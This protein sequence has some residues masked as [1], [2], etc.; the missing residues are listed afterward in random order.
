METLEIAQARSINVYE[1]I[2]ARS[3]EICDRRKLA[4][5]TADEFNREYP[6]F[7]PNHPLLSDFD[8]VIKNVEFLFLYD[9]I[10]RSTHGPRECY[11]LFKALTTKYDLEEDY[12]RLLCSRNDDEIHSIKNKWLDFA[13]HL[14]AFFLNMEDDEKLDYL[15]KKEDFVSYF[16][17]YSEIYSEAIVQLYYIGTL[18]ILYCERNGFRLL[19]DPN[20]LIRFINNNPKAKINPE[21]LLDDRFVKAIAHNV[22]PIEF[23][24]QLCAISQAG[25]IG[26][27]PFLEEHKK[28]CDHMISKIEDG[29]I[30]SLDESDI[31]NSEKSVH[32]MYK[33]YKKQILE[34]I[35]EKF[36]GKDIGKKT[37]LQELTKYVVMGLWMSRNFETDPH[38]LFIDIETLYEFAIAHDR[39]LKGFHFYEF[40]MNFEDADLETIL[41]FYEKTKD[42]PLKSILYDDW[43]QEKIQMIDEINSSLWS[44]S[45]L[46]PQTDENDGL[47]HYDITDL[48][49][50]ILVSNTCVNA[51]DRKKV[52]ELIAKVRNGKLGVIYMSLQDAEHQVVYRDEEPDGQTSI[53]FIFGPLDH[54]K[55]GIVNHEDAYSIGITEVAKNNLSIYKRRLYTVDELMNDTWR[56]NEISYMASPEPFMPIGLLA[57]ERI[58]AGER[59]VAEE[60][61]IPIYFRKDIINTV[62]SRSHLTQKLLEHRYRHMRQF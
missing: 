21:M 31:E 3:K 33:I 55:V 14:A 20:K 45:E 5:D 2:E 23:Y 27:Q 56:Y 62:S 44:L 17:R 47:T 53:K 34:K 12:N 11:T 29:I 35:R 13:A 15:F 28:F 26:V 41:E 25:A 36:K 38:N 30:P 18:R 7:T 61:G 1:I 22:N 43:M 57:E 16:F 42:I 4:I 51:K 19:G 54:D 39:D 52:D 46:E 60:L 59:Y 10:Y 24:D 6:L 32:F 8:W 9:Y 48:R 58:T 49:G 40:L 37:M 50:K